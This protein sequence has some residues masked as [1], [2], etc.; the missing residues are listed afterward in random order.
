[1]I[2]S[3]R[4]QVPDKSCRICGG[5]ITERGLG[6]GEDI[7]PVEY[8]RVASSIDISGPGSPMRSKIPRCHVRQ[9]LPPSLR[10]RENKTLNQQCAI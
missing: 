6:V 5:E 1:M 4:R 9:R 10:N 8:G 7:F 3:M 2:R